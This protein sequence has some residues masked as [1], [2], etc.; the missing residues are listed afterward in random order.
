MSELNQI[1]N[2]ISTEPQISGLLLECLQFKANPYQKEGIPYQLPA[3]LKSLHLCLL[4]GTIEHTGDWD[5]S[6][7]II[8]KDGTEI[9]TEPGYCDMIINDKG[10]LV[11]ENGPDDEEDEEFNPYSGEYRVGNNIIIPSVLIQTIL[12]HSN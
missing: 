9:Q 12:I 4:I 7:H 3:F 6:L 8:L 2:L 11:I 5:P 1:T 10:E